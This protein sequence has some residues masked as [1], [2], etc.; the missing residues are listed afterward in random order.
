MGS[1]YLNY[2][3]LHS[4][5]LLTLVN[6]K[7]RFIWLDIDISRSSFDSQIFLYSDLRCYI[8]DKN[9]G[10]LLAESFVDN[11]LQVKYFFI[12]YHAFPLST[13]LMKPF[14]CRILD[15]NERAYNYHLLWE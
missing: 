6:T 13:L 10:V 2:K 9:I 4:H 5:I 14:S 7:Y 15:M 8:D 11:W 3:D 1:K 12:G